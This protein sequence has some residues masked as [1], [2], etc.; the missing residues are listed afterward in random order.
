VNCR[1]GGTCSPM[2]SGRPQRPAK[3]GQAQNHMNEYWVYVIRSLKANY[4]YVGIS[5]DT[6]RRFKEHN[7]GHNK[8]TKPYAPFRILLTEKFPDRKS[9]RER[10][11]FLKSGKGREFLSKYK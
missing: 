2:A 4:T 3:G 11:K 5:N 10:E 9:S 7:S 8:S 6:N 1:D